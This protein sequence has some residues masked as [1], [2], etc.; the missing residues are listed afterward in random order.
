MF[1]P[2]TGRSVRC[3]RTPWASAGRTDQAK[4]DGV[5]RIAVLGDSMV[6]GL[7]SRAGRCAAWSGAPERERC[8]STAPGGDEWNLRVGPGAKLAY[9]G[10][11]RRFAP[12]VV[13]SRSSTATTC[14]TRSEISDQYGRMYLEIA[15]AGVLL[16]RTPKPSHGAVAR[17]EPGVRMDPPPDRQGRSNP[18]RS[19]NR[20]RRAPSAICRTAIR[21]PAGMASARSDRRRARGDVRR[22]WPP[23]RAGD[24]ERAR[25][26]PDP[27]ALRDWAGPVANVLD[28]DVQGGE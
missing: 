5:R 7:A 19:A 1:D 14:R 11:V 2:E 15:D 21:V 4:P 26:L 3:G 20:S 8:R 10:L 17:P 9:R 18:G 22:R 27:E 12:D 6:A 23:R 25:D 16:A 24:P 13:V 28:L